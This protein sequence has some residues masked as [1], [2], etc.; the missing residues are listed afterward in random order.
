MQRL[1]LRITVN[2]GVKTP[3]PPWHILIHW[4]PHEK[5][6]SLARYDTG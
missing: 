6:Q 2:N 5:K 4:V 3:W 1:W